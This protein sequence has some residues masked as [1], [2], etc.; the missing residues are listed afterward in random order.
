MSRHLQVLSPQK[1]AQIMIEEIQNQFLEFLD[2]AHQRFSIAGNWTANNQGIQRSNTEIHDFRAAVFIQLFSVLA[3]NLRDRLYALH[4]ALL[5]WRDSNE[6]PL[7]QS[8]RQRDLNP[9]QHVR[10]MLRILLDFSRYTQNQRIQYSVFHETFE[11]PFIVEIEDL[12]R[13]LDIEV[14]H[15]FRPQLQNAVM[16]SNRLAYGLY[17]L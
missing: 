11:N 8:L 7:L 12:Q 5:H 1:Q 16:P 15:H 10:N 14:R 17:G 4:N 3:Q 2:M 6:W 13:L 9:N